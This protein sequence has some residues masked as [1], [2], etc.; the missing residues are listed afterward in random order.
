MLPEN[1]Y[2]WGI[3]GCIIGSAVAGLYGYPELSSI[4]CVCG[5]ILCAVNFYGEL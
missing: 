3:L 4:F 5:I 1:R 2:E